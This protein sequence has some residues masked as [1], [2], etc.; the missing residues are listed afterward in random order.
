MKI[1]IHGLGRMGMQIAHKLA[2]SGEHTVIAHNRSPEP[3]DEATA[4]GAVKAYEKADVLREFG[5][6]QVVIWIMLPDN[7]VDAQLDEWLTLVPK[8]SILIDGGNSDFRV[9]KQQNERVSAAGCYLLDVGVS[10]GIWGYQNGFPLMCGG[11]SAEAFAALEPALKT[12]VQPGGMYNHFGASG[13]GH[14]VKMVHN[15]IEY[16][17]MES[18]GEGFRMLHDGPYKGMDLAKAA[19]LWQHHSVITSWLNEL[20]RDALAENP[21]LEGISG[22]VAESGEARWT[23]EA[24]KDMDI[25]LPSIQAAFDVRV[26]SQKGEV[27]FATKVVAAQRNKFGGHNLNGEGAEAGVREQVAHQGGEGAA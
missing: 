1:A 12:L 23:L 4:F 7:V 19:D 20:S 10:G 26:A 9:T 5:D 13:A 16:G 21:E 11:D 6:D 3:I 24:A 14:F 2:E 8:G 22:Y 17:I 25:T 18:L 15:A 27:N